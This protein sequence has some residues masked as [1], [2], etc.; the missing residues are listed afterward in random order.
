MNIVGGVTDVGK[1]MFQSSELS[2][3]SP[4]SQPEASQRNDNLG[5]HATVALPAG[6]FQ[7]WRGRGGDNGIW[8][9]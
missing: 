4:G 9:E 8:D 5:L 3:P 1:M 6:Y 2:C 7:I